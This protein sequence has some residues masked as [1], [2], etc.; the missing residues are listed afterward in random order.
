MKKHTIL[1]NIDPSFI[2][3]FVITEYLLKNSALIKSVTSE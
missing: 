1:P 2:V 3:I